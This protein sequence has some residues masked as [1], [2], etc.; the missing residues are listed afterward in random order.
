M[1]K[2]QRNS[3]EVKSNSSTPCIFL[4]ND[5]AAFEE[6]TIGFRSKLLKRMGYQGKFLNINGQ[7]IINPV[8]VVELPYIQDLGILGRRLGNALKEPTNHE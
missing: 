1:E 6:H 2:L 4:D 5:F 8:K 7:G 3:R